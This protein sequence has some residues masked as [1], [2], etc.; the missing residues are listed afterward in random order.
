MRGS[1]RLALLV[2]IAGGMLSFAIFTPRMVNKHNRHHHVQIRVD[3]DGH[4]MRFEAR[5][6]RRERIEERRKRRRHPR[7][8]R[9]E[10]AEIEA[11]MER[12]REEVMRARQDL[13]R[14]LEEARGELQR[15]RVKEI[16]EGVRIHVEEVAE[17]PHISIRTSGPRLNV[18]TR[19]GDP[20]V[21]V[22]GVRVDGGREALKEIS[23][24]RIDR[25]EVLKGEAAVATYGDEAK[26]GVVQIF[27][28]PS[29]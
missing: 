29:S 7:A 26:N 19:E 3:H 15:V 5:E 11:E 16:A 6:L 13:E 17:G 20:I 28:K 14:S 27:L 24:E 2:A 21:Y 1:T 8:E 25:V 4:E 23:P 10:R 18:F 12:A 9:L 22:D